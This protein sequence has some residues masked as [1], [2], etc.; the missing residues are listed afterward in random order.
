MPISVFSNW[1]FCPSSLFKFYRLKCDFQHIAQLMCLYS[2]HHIRD[3]VY[4]IETR[5]CYIISACAFLLTHLHLRFDH[6]SSKA[7]V[8]AKVTGQTAEIGF[9]EENLYFCFILCIFLFSSLIF[10][11]FLSLLHLIWHFL[12]TPPA[13]PSLIVDVECGINDLSIR[14]LLKYQE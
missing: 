10:W 4:F 1:Y 14:F 13:L 2:N 8:S 7:A 6:Y 12:V 3:S 9:S 11:A 5:F